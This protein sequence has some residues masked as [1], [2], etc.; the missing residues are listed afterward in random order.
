MPDR[1]SSWSGLIVANLRRSATGRR[2]VAVRTNERAAASLGISVFS[3][4]LYAFAV[5]SAIAGV[6][7]ILLA[8]RSQNIQ[9]IEYNVFASI[10]SVGYAVIGGLGFVLGAV[11]AAPNAIGGIGTRITEDWLTSVTSGISSSAACSSC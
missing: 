6:A 9:Y 8:F 3:V 7:G 1:A 11:F 2:L 4:K 10:N 5:A